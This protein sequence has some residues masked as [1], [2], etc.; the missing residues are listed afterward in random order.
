M[1]EQKDIPV[2]TLFKEVDDASS[3]DDIVVETSSPQELNTSSNSKLEASSSSQPE[4]R[5]KDEPIEEP[6]VCNIFQ[7]VPST[8][9]LFGNIT[10]QAQVVIQD[11]SKG[12]FNVST[13][14]NKDEVQEVK[15]TVE[16]FET[17]LPAD[18]PLH[19]NIIADDNAM[20]AKESDNVPNISIDQSDPLDEHTISKSETFESPFSNFDLMTSIRI[21]DSLDSLSNLSLDQSE[22]NP[23][24][25]RTINASETSEI[26]TNTAIENKFPST[27]VSSSNP[28]SKDVSMLPSKNDAMYADDPQ[29]VQI[30]TDNSK[31][32]ETLVSKVAFDVASTLNQS[33][34]KSK[35]TEKDSLVKSEE[36]KTILVETEF[37]M[38]VESEVAVPSIANKTDIDTLTI[39][40][41]M[42]SDT[43]QP[44]AASALFCSG[45][46]AT[47]FG[48]IG[49]G[50]SATTG[51]A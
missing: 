21:N 18:T 16:A 30:E 8:E 45:D 34:E 36:P 4:Q 43:P 13:T 39:G 32:D 5:V 48:K 38:P 51:I 12:Q 44:P 7:S 41:D 35:N 23:C 14:A 27:V 22:I 1:D 11:Q 2:C 15:S 50:S 31:G 42:P 3:K 49:D 24:N 9:D 17:T 20:V 25:S 10:T 37:L 46:E 6:G 26:T 40:N 29:P 47:P 19:Q 28:S 33:S